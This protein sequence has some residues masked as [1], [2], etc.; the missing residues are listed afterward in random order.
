MYRVLRVSPGQGHTLQI[1]F[2][3]GL[4]GTVDLSSRL[5]GHVFEPLRDPAFFSQVGIDE[6]G[7]VCWPNGADLAP[8]ALYGIISSTTLRTAL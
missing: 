1:D 4:S 5:F 8:D 6:F 2:A 7:V 3:D